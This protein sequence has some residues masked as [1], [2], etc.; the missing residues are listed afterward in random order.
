MA[1]G[2][3]PLMKIIAGVQQPTSGKLLLEGKEIK[4][5]S[6]RDAGRHG[7]GIIFQELNLFPNLSV[8]ENIFMAR[9]IKKGVVIDKAAQKEQ[10]RK[11]IERLRQPI[12][13]DDM[14]SDLRIGHQQIVEIAKALAEGREYSHYG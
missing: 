3:R 12:E 6:T 1:R 8:T 10:T 14:V 11:I 4:I 7:I 13:P 9:E 2:N 5:K